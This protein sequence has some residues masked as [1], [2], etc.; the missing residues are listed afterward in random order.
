METIQMPINRW[1]DKEAVA[2]AYSGI[3]LSHKESTFESVLV[4]W[5]NLESVT[6]V[7]VSQKEKHIIY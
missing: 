2:H 3:L 1:M 6:R 4:K 7:E 5:I